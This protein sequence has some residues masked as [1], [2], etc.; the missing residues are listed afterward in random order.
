[1]SEEANK[2][3]DAPAGDAPAAGPAPATAPAAGEAAPSPVGG[4][5]PSGSPDTGQKV[6]VG[7]KGEAASGEP[8][9][10]EP[11]NGEPTN[12]EPHLGLDVPSDSP[13][14]H[15]PGWGE[16]R[17]IDDLTPAEPHPGPHHPKLGEWAA[18]GICGNDI[19]SSC[20][21]VS[22]LCALYAGPYAPLALLLVAVLLY[23]F[24]KIYAEVGTALP[25]NGGAY[26]VLLNTTSKYK[27]SMAACLT[28]L[29]YVATAVI[30]ANEGMHYAHNLWHALDITVA[31]VA[32]LGLFALLNLI[33]ITESARVALAIFVFHIVTLVLL[34]FIAGFIALRD[35]ALLL[36]NLRTPPPHGIGY[37]LFFGFSAALLGI[38]GFESS[39]NFI[40]EQEEGVFP[41]TLRNM[42][43]AVAVFNPLIS[44][45]S[46]GVLPMAELTAHKQDLL[47]EMG[48]VASGR[49]LQIWVSIDAV[50]VLSGAVL[51]SYVGVTGLVRRM[52][53]D[54][55][56][57]QLLLAQ[58]KLRGTNHWIII[59]FF[60]LCCSI[61]FL[62]AG[63]IETL[64]GVYTI[65]FLGVMALFALGNMLLKVERNRL[66]RSDRA[67]WP[68]VIIALLAVL[69][70]L[71]GN[72]VL[73][74]E[75]VK[76][77]AVYFLVAAGVVTLMFLR[78]PILRACLFVIQAVL[79]RLVGVYQG[80]GRWIAARIDEIQSQKV[81]F[82]TRGDSVANLNSAALYVVEN[83][84]TDNLVVVH[85]YE[86][87]QEIP[88]SLAEDLAFLDRAY[89]Q[90]RI[91][92][93]AV[94]GKF[95]PELVEA[96]SERLNVPRNFMFI[97]CPG[98]RFPHRLE[99]LQGVRLIV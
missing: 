91:D 28:L 6:A 40:E 78:I 35:P 63:K 47:A 15:F 52:S 37:A 16:A 22:A 84:H 68:A 50:L 95:T 90:V 97:G 55:C 20:L 57:P 5:A 44:L 12:G 60:A 71:V 73:D 53:L 45:L 49:W 56:L 17:R 65:S 69:A 77:F 26:N 98:D 59:G 54:R 93:L 61:L 85:V 3:G 87:E 34:V 82:F 8:T 46:L 79:T 36:E 33:G 92:F 64:A 18:T 31:T 96:L 7:P 2:G 51:T 41:K 1:M 72:V 9:S 58:N 89:P 21:Y 25:L 70:G 39:A 80:L 67:S 62:T 75:Y 23:L 14:W 13:V 11:S 83:E 81:V 24:R 94:R 10:G 32:L 42:W 76:V 4:P 48:R 30:S 43:I 29:S 66:P 38:S 19:T 86:D 74:P 99:S 88:R 27:A